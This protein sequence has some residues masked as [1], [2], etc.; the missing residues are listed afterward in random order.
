M[1]D[2][3]I[4]SSK[5]IDETAETSGSSAPA[6]PKTTAKKAPVSAR[7]K[8]A[9]TGAKK[10][11][12][13]KPAPKKKPVK[14]EAEAEDK[15][16]AA[17]APEGTP[18]GKY[19]K[20]ES[21]PATAVA[22]EAAAGKPVPAGKPG[23]PGGP[24]GP[25]GPGGP[26]K[27]NGKPK[28]TEEEERRRR[29]I[30]ILWLTMF[31]ILIIIFVWVFY[32]LFAPGRGG[33]VAAKKC[34]QCH[35]KE[36]ARQ[37]GSQ[38]LHDPFGKELCTN[39]HVEPNTPDKGCDTQKKI[40]AVVSGNLDKVCTKC[41]TT[42]KNQMSKK[43]VHKPFKGKRCTNCHDPHASQFERL[44]VLPTQ[45]LCVSCHYGKD[46]TQAYQ[47]E[48]A[49]KR[50]CV[51]CHEPHSADEAKDLVLPVNQLC[52]SCHFKVAQ[53]NLRL[54]KH[55]PFLDGNCIACHKSH[56]SPNKRILAME[57]NT[58]CESCHPNIGVDFQRYSHHPL[59]REPMVNCGACHLYHSADWPRLL[60]LENTVNCY[61]SQCH[62]GLQAYFD[63]SEHNSTV[64]GMLAKQ[65][66]AVTCMACH[67]PHGA[68][69]GKLLT[70]DRYT[71]CLVCHADKTG[72]PSHGT[73]AHPYNPPFIDVWHGD[74]L[75]CGSC[76]NF[77]GSPYPA[78]RLALGDDLCLKCHNPKDLENTF[79]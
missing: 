29:I 16:S 77:H 50:N 64:M 36:M 24:G 13:K 58:L 66:L 27:A 9:A 34:L 5:P 57:Y 33:P 44:T 63:T 4:D 14:P 54:Y 72:N 75:W 78:M 21:A 39:C 41:H 20:I 25:T 19:V 10:P 26:G 68:N 73:F 53:Q 56:S 70:V 67:S 35:E 11:A 60:P 74:Y 7:K 2:K 3:E 71:V 76:H 15:P 52:Y 37:L 49:Q 32:G 48:P 46:F 38:Y 61:Q 79:R 30:L 45:E 69:Y 12:A 18:A 43:F 47:H 59:G 65:N 28:P 42:A 23:G 62:P 31:A 1:A 51:D 40:Y 17:K 8:P 6:K 55:K 22:A